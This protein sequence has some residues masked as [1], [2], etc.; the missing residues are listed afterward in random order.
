MGDTED[1][2]SARL[3]TQAGEDLSLATAEARYRGHDVSAL[4]TCGLERA[5]ELLRCHESTVRELAKAGKI[6]GRKVGRAWVFV[7]ADLLEYVREGSCR[8]TNGEASGGSTSSIHEQGSD[9]A[10]LLARVIERVRSESTTSSAPNSGSAEVVSL[11]T[12]RSMR[13]PRAK[14][15]P[16]AAE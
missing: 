14:T 5:V 16:T 6:R 4:P 8:S 2:R 15:N 11:S 9:C 10:N 12:R 1:S 3:A 7:E 13:G